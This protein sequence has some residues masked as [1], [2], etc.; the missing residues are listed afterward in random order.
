MHRTLLR[1]LRKHGLGPEHAPSADAWAAFV[2]EVARSYDGHDEHRYLLQRAMEISAEEMRT[3]AQSLASKNALLELEI[4]E[5]ARTAAKLRYAATYDALTG[6]PSRRALLD[7]LAQ[8]IALGA[9]YAVLFLDLDDFKVIN[10]SLGHEVGDHVLRGVADRL[11]EALTPLDS[12][13]PYASRLGGDEFVVLLR[14]VS[15]ERSVLRA[16]E[17]IRDAF[18]RPVVAGQQSFALSASV[19]MLMG[20]PEYLDAHDVLRDADTAMYRAKVSGKGRCA[21]FNDYMHAENLDRMRLI[22]D[23]WHGIERREFVLAYQPVID[24]T[25]GRLAA[26]ETLLRWKHPTR[27]MVQPDSFIEVAEHSGAIVD[28]G[29][30]A[31]DSA[32]AQLAGWTRLGVLG[33]SVRVSVNIS[34]RQMSEDGILDHIFDACA[35]HRLSPERLILEVTESTVMADLER[36][37]AVLDTAR[38]HGC[39]VYMDDFG[40]GLSSI[41]TLHRMPFDTVKIDRSFVRHVSTDRAHAAVVQ[42]IVTLAHNLGL[43]VVAEGVEHLGQLAQLQACDCDFVQGYLFSRPLPVE[44]VPDWVAASDRA[45]N[46]GP[47]R[48]AA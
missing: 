6:L 22:Q 39:L 19:G 3:L 28:I 16:V 1:Q 37:S 21:V 24:A 7:E 34:K 23:L 20:K 43:S 9:R 30:Q 18:T 45:F 42:S 15:D 33:D 25:S 12:L 17:R 44:D 38:A 35:R 29:R 13:A 46:T 36:V 47:A 14:T 26:F 41:S 40:T 2:R 48:E 10:D 8:R 11:R 5:H 31:I 27:G 4:Q 32:C